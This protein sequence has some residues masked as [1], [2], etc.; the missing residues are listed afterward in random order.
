MAQP[1]DSEGLLFACRAG[2][3]EALTAVL[4]SGPRASRRVAAP[5]AP[6]QLPATPHLGQR[7]LA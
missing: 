3:R 1:K 6:R 5:F 4:D 2:V 7:S